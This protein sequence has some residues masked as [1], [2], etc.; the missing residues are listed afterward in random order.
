MNDVKR[1]SK[2]HYYW[3]NPDQSYMFWKRRWGNA[4]TVPEGF[5][6]ERNLA[7]GLASIEALKNLQR[8]IWF[9]PACQAVTRDRRVLDIYLKGAGSIRTFC[10]CQSTSRSLNSYCISCKPYFDHSADPFVFAISSH[11]HLHFPCMSI[12]HP[13]SVGTMNLAAARV[14]LTLSTLKS[15]DWSCV[16]LFRRCF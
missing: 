4:A 13:K 7:K 12:A 5:Q 2:R 8:I 9:D 15:W 6:L 16:G 1:I 14:S 11:L 3:L 10:A